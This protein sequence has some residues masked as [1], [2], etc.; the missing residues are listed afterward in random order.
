[1]KK[2]FDKLQPY[3]EKGMAFQSA[4]TL[5]QWDLETQAPGLGEENTSKVVGILSDGYLHSYINPEVEQIL[6][7]IEHHKKNTPIEKKEEGIYKELK[8]LQEQL[9]NIPPEEYRKF[10]ELSAT[11]TS[12]WAKAKE[13]ND[14]EAFAPTLEKIIDYKKKLMKYRGVAEKDIYNNLLQDYEI[15]FG[16]QELDSFFE[17]IKKELIPLIKEIMEKK[18][19]LNKKYEEK[20]IPRTVEYDIE[21]QKKFCNDLAVYIGFGLNKGVIAES[22]HPFTTALHNHDVRVTNHFDT[23]HPESAIFSIIHETGHALYEMNIKDEYTQTLLGEGT[24]MGMHESQSRFWENMIGRSKAFWKPIYGKLQNTFPEG[25]KN[26]SLEDFIREINQVNTDFIRTEADELTYPLHIIIRYEIE[27]EIFHN[28]KLAIKDLEKV[29][30]EKYKE[31]LGITPSNASEGILQDIHWAC[32]DFGYFPS[33]AIGTAIA[34][35]IYSHMKTVM[36]IEQY[37]EE[38]NL[39]PIR[40][41]LKEHI[42]Q[43]GKE[44]TTNEILYDMMGEEFN[45]DYY[46]EYLKE[47]YS[48]IYHI[49]YFIMDTILDD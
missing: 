22:A 18:S 20:T 23:K 35:Q 12:I 13:K 6:K 8:R 42:H 19:G 27:K 14:Y 3:L 24:S 26:L 30:N 34:A 36:P 38:G 46:I 9:G 16:E 10:S 5:F 21:K 17:K 15:G 11:A 47:K 49:S 43:F 7:K 1:M 29:W 33:Y 31:Y 37:L 45:P 2:Y 28:K 41:Y 40:T 48:K 32:G 44:K 4:L 39:L 25:F